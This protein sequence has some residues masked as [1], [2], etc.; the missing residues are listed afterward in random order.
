MNGFRGQRE[1]VP[2]HVRVR[3]IGGGVSLL[4][5]NEVGELKRI[6]NEE[7][8][9][10][11]AYQIVISLFGVELHGKA[12]GIAC[13]ICRPLFPTHRGK[14]DKHLRALAHLGKELGLVCLVTS[15]LTSK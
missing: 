10:I 15:A 3:K 4:C 14:A 8:R 6:P 13:G 9:R 7:N 1:E 2:E 11:I 5:M 12:T